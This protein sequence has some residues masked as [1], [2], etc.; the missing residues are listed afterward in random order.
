[1]LLAVRI[2][3]VVVLLV[4]KDLAALLEELKLQCPI[5]KLDSPLEE[6]SPGLLPNHPTKPLLSELT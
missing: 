4:A 2:S 3:P 1:M 5:L 6:D